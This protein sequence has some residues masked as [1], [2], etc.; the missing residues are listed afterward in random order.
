MYRARLTEA[1]QG[2]L[3]RRARDPGIKRRTRDRLEM[4][5]L[6]DS[7]WSI[8]RIARHFRLNEKRVRF[9]IRRFLEVG[10]AGLLDRPHPGRQSALTPAVLEA[11]G[12]ELGKG[13][14]I[15]T[16]GQLVEWLAEHHGVRLSAKWLSRLLR[17]VRLSYK[18][19][20]RQVRHKQDPAQ[21]AERAADLETLERG[22]LRGG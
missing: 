4:V 3:Q 8:P 9:W 10:F 6:S 5:R 11:L 18:R 20:Q 2:D 1:Q 7:G 17:R 15:W 21:V 13:D 16:A 19:T 14:R 12:H 22:A